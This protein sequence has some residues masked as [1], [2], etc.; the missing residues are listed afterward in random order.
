MIQ[1]ATKSTNIFYLVALGDHGFVHKVYGL[2]SSSQ[3]LNV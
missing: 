3:M 2:V 1:H